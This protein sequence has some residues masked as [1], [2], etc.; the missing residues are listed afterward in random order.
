MADAGPERRPDLGYGAVGG[1]PAYPAG[2][3]HEACV[4]VPDSAPQLPLYA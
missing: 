3:A 1:R 2:A 4:T